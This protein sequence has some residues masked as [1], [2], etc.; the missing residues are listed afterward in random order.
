MKEVVMG[1]LRLSV[2]LCLVLA[3]GGCGGSDPSGQIKSLTGDFTKLITGRIVD[4]PISEAL[5]GVDRN[6]NHSL[7]A[8]EILTKSDS[9]GFYSLMVESK[10]VYPLIMQSGLDIST[11]LP[12]EGVLLAPMP[13]D[14]TTQIISPLTTL[15][16]FGASQNLIKQMF[17]LSADIALN[18]VDPTSNL[19]LLKAGVKAHV[20]AIQLSKATSR[21]VETIY[22]EVAKLS[23]MTSGSIQ[24]VYAK[25]A[26]GSAAEI[27]ALIDTSLQTIDQKA[28]EASVVE[29]QSVALGAISEA[30]SKTTSDLSLSSSL[31]NFLSDVAKEK[32]SVINTVGMSMTLISSGIFEMWTGTSDHGGPTHLVT[33]SKDFYIGTYEVTQ[34]DWEAV[35]GKGGWPNVA[36]PAFGFGAKYPIYDV[37]WFDANA[38]I[39]RLNAMEGTDKYRLPTEAEWEYSAR[40]GE[41]ATSYLPITPSLVLSYAWFRE[42]SGDEAHPVG[43]KLPNPWGLYDT[44]GNVYEWVQDWRAPLPLVAQIDPIG[45]PFSGRDKVQKG[46]GYRSSI[47]TDLSRRPGGRPS[48]SRRNLGFRI[49]R[50][51]D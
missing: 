51:L 14:T 42:N 47:E 33:I 29:F 5:V 41:G 49:L 6:F 35:M 39:D 37:T 8:G 38:F 25:L 17:A 44:L 2:V 10:S 9:Q 16:N 13:S 11:H 48:E 32:P 24:S 28:T 1:L 50:K 30:I 18:E 36:L 7:E 31:V 12:F 22:E 43:Q 27:G 15:L 19:G 34:G 40:A 45:R 46:W 20:L 21:P 23:E 3:L 4:G 26:N